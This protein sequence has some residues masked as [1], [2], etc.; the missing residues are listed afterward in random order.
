[1]TVDTYGPGIQIPVSRQ[2]AS[3]S[4]YGIPMRAA[5]IDLDA[6]QQDYEANQ[7]ITTGC[8]D[9]T[10]FTTTLHGVLLFAGAQ[11]MAMI[12]LSIQLG[13]TAITIP[14]DGNVTDFLM[15]TLPAALV[16]NQTWY[17]SI[18]NGRNSGEAQIAA[19]GQVTTR[20]WTPAQNI[21]ASTILKLSAF[22]LTAE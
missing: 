4:Q 9:Q 3:A 8:V 20:C 14:A 17:G 12:S 18:G 10:N 21:A 22:Y 15:T 11:Q 13:V 19:N 1:M 2:K 7:V 5:I 6:R 16:P